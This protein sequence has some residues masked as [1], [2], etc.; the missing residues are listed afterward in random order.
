MHEISLVKNMLSVLDR[1]LDS[2]EVGEVKT[3]HLEVGALKYIVPDIMEECF[4]VT[5]KHEKLEGSRIEIKVLPVRIECLDC[6]KTSEVNAGEYI[7][8]GCSSDNVEL[9]GGDEFLIKGIEW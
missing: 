3:V 9:A 2:P 7:C 4:N 8:P 5:P 1:E 6:G